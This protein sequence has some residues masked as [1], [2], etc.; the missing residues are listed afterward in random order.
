MTV[1]F[2]ILSIT[3]L[4]AYNAW[5]FKVYALDIKKAVKKKKK[6]LKENYNGLTYS[7]YIE[8]HAFT[9][10]NKNTGFLFWK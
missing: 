4:Y 6:L 9:R 1:Q 2:Y 7:D 5:I 3:D 10:R 8:T